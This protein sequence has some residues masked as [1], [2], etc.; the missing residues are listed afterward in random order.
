MSSPGF[1]YYY[2]ILMVQ[3]RS[4]QDP[5]AGSAREAAEGRVCHFNGGGKRIRQLRLFSY[6]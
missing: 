3:R 2:T 6:A 4:G 1:V 5:E